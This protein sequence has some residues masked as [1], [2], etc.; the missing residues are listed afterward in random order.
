MEIL[1]HKEPDNSS[2]ELL[3]SNSG[4]PKTHQH[5]IQGT[6]PIAATTQHHRVNDGKQATQHETN[7]KK[8][9][10]HICNNSVKVKGA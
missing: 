7:N 10:R 5:T 9:Y 2:R 3:K 8:I 6:T 1:Q 4:R